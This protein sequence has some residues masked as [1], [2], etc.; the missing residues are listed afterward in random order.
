VAAGTNAR[1]TAA[2]SEAAIGSAKGYRSG[3]EMAKS[4]ITALI[5]KPLIRKFSLSRVFP[6]ALSR[7]STVTR[8]A[9]SNH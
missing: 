5:F 3:V 9:D 1:V 2:C 7:T 8:M 4:T 6:I